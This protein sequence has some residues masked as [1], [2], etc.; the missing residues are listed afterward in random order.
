MGRSRF[1]PVSLVF[2]LVFAAAG[3]I[4]LVGGNLIQDGQF[5]LPAGLVGLGIALLY[6]V[7]RR[8]IMAANTD[9]GDDDWA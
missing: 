5:L 9:D 3:M 8:A 6:Q 4:V 1:D 2:G 7:T